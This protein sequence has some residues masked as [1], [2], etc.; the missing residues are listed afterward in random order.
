MSLS[1]LT[2]PELSY[3]MACLA[4]AAYEDNCRAIFAE[5]GFTKHYKFNFNVCMSHDIFMKIFEVFKII[6]IKITCYTIV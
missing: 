2:L 5:H 1:Q 4:R 6:F 3:V